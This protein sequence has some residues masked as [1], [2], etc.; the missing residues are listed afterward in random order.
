VS[1]EKKADLIVRKTI[2]NRPVAHGRDVVVNIRIFNV[3]TAYVLVL[4]VFLFVINLT[5]TSRS[6]SVAL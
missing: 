4:L 1:A 3:G 5:K 6:L 2:L